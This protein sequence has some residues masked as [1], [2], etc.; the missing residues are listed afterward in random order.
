MSD[1]K[2]L[3]C[4]ERRERKRGTFLA[5]FQLGERTWVH[6]LLFRTWHEWRMR[7]HEWT[8]DR[9]ARRKAGCA[10]ECDIQRERG[11]G[12]RRKEWKLKDGQGAARGIGRRERDVGDIEPNALNKTSVMEL[13][14]GCVSLA[15]VT[16]AHSRVFSAWSRLLLRST[17]CSSRFFTNERVSYSRVLQRMLG[18]DG[19]VLRASEISLD[20]YLFQ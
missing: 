16:R 18:I 6:E 2:V 4:M 7:P 14:T 5:I 20:N 15:F 3:L 12:E 8:A 13:M 19:R 11:G 10:S 17:L 1:R 9:R